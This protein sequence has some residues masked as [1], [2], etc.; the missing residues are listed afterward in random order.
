MTAHLPLR[1][2]RWTQAAHRWLGLALGVQVLLW[3]ASG[4]FMSLVDMDRVR[5]GGTRAP[6]LAPAL[7]A[8]TYFPPGG[9]IA[10]MDD[11]ESIT[12]KWWNGRVVYLVSAGG[13]EGL[14]DAETGDA[15]YPLGETIVRDIASKS[16]L[17][18]GRIVR[19]SLL[20]RAP[21]DWR[22]ELPVWRVDISD[23]ARTRIYISPSSGE[24]LANRNRLWRAYDFFW[25]LHIMD[26]EGRSNYSNPLLRLFSACSVLFALTGIVLVATRLQTGRYAED[27]RS[28]SGGKKNK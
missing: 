12:L 2:R 1:W 24:V 27:V 3:M 10:S 22:G 21:V 14:F 17:G 11:V 28:F 4:A 5:G 15:L 26:Y 13:A 23:K 6:N 19:A 16:Y 25:M 9:I 20:D 7:D 8:R 18:E